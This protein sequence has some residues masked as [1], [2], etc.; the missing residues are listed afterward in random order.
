VDVHDAA[1]WH[2]RQYFVVTPATTAAVP[3]DVWPR[4]TLTGR[5][6]TRSKRVPDQLL[7]RFESGAWKGE[8]RCP[9]TDAVFR[10][11]FPAGIFNIRMRPQGF[12]AQSRSG[13]ELKVGQVADAGAFEFIEG[14]SIT[15]RVEVPRG[16]KGKIT[17]VI[18]T[19]TPA[20]AS[21]G[22]AGAALFPI[23]ANA[24]QNGFFQLDGLAPGAYV[25]QAAHGRALSTDAIDVEVRTGREAELL[26][27][28]RLERPSQIGL[29]VIPAAAPDGR[30]WHV[31]VSR[32]AGERQLEPVAESNTTEAGQWTSVRLQPSRYELSIGTMDGEVWHREEV[33]LSAADRELLVTLT[34]D[35]R[36]GSLTLGGNPLQASLTFA[37]STGFSVNAK[38]DDKGEFTVRVPRTSERQ[39]NVRVDSAHP[40]VRRTILLDLPE[41]SSESLVIELPSSILLGEVVDHRG[42]PVEDASITIAGGDPRERIVQRRTRA[43]GT[44]EVHGLATGT[45]TVVASG[46][47]T[48]SATVTVDLRADE[49]PEPV[50]LILRNMQR[51]RGRVVSPRGAVSGASVQ[52]VATDVQQ[53][54]AFTRPTDANGEFDLAVPPDARTFD[55]VVAPPGH[56]YVLTGA[57]LGEPLL[58]NAEQRGGTL[59]VQSSRG[60]MPYIVHNGGTIPTSTVGHAWPMRTE[61]LND[62]ST[63]FVIPMM[64]PGA[65]SACVVPNGAIEQFRRSG[66][67]SGGRCVSGF[68]A[69]FGALTLDTRPR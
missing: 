27:P 34:I 59:T 60:D 40:A 5:I 48:E 44:F 2:Q 11:A 10:C 25:V 43:D 16:F 69:P 65:Y 35:E 63:Q 9:I 64:E 12:I 36:R 6:S 13:V 62:T 28:L 58:I 21:R 20:A 54:I 45:Y 50:R 24:A 52:A 15:G 57:R 19:A 66:G 41:N 23:R 7:V 47:L 30:P 31:R 53:L 61:E 42:V 49:T 37:G 55:V 32:Y 39:L 3:V 46:F 26:A 14:Q 8:L 29:S 18:V 56:S 67:A 33:A 38:T 22:F 17:D 68:L 51:L 1:L 4:S